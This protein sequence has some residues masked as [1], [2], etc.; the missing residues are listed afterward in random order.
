MHFLVFGEELELWCFVHPCPIERNIFY[1][2]TLHSM[3]YK[4]MFCQTAKMNSRQDKRG[5]TYI[6]AAALTNVIPTGKLFRLTLS[7]F[8]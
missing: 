2:A 3:R 7:I 8:L 4:A 1:R 5:K 6:R